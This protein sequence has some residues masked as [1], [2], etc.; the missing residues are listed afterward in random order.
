MDNSVLWDEEG[1]L[2]QEAP[3]PLR[4]SWDPLAKEQ[5]ARR[6]SR[7]PRTTK[8]RSSVGWFVHRYGWRAYGIPLLLAATVLAIIEM[9]NGGANRNADPELA[10][11]A[12]PVMT[13]VISGVTSVVTLPPETVTVSADTPPSGAGNA[14]VDGTAG[15]ATT[16]PPDPPSSYPTNITPG[17]LPAGGD[18]TKAG[19]KS[20]RV[21]P[22]TTKRVGKGSDLRTYAV[23]IEDGVTVDGGD[24]AFADFVDTTLD[25]ARS[26]TSPLMGDFSL[27]RVAPSDNPDFMVTL[28]SQMTIRELCGYD[29]KL[30]ASCYNSS[31]GRVLIN[32]A[33]W[34]RGAV[35][36]TG[37]IGS[38]R[39]YA[40]NH[41][42]G[43]ALGFG[44]QPCAENGG[45]A[46]IMMQQSWSVAN[47]DLTQLD[48]QT[49]P[50]DGKVCKPNPWPDPL[51]GQGNPTSGN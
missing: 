18:F 46:P 32:D 2:F 22:G 24:K 43:H 10:S 1:D 4:A 25:D 28:T 8:R 31:A 11:V 7:A 17:Q 13:T 16:V 49:I 3:Q 20:Y 29:I 19:D 26:W 27:Q 14:P 48:P 36:Y 38:Y 6:P 9:T 42:V 21:V 41:E 5:G 15:V 34:V 51:G 35:S 44:H 40:I 12:A 47:D 23:E 45:L 39:R 37:D 30:E 33:R 50:L